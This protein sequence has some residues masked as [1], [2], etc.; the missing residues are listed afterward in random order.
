MELKTSL[1][2][3]KKSR[4]E[5]YIEAFHGLQGTGLRPT[6]V[7]P[8]VFTLED[9]SLILGLYVDNMLI[10]SANEDS[11]ERVVRSIKKLWDIKDIW[12]VRKILGSSI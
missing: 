7:E 4:R 12:E 11:I 3:L 1:Y 5:W 6:A 2:G 10:L 8:S 9:K